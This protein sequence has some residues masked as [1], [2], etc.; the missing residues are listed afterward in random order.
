METNSREKCGVL[1]LVVVQALR[2][3]GQDFPEESGQ[4]YDEKILSLIFCFWNMLYQ[5]IGNTSKEN[6]PEIIETKSRNC[7]EFGWND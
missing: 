3:H 6:R 1:E 2:N 4:E 7:Y 5:S